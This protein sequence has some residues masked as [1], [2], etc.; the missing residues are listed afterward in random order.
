M[1]GTVYFR[2]PDEVSMWLKVLAISSITFIF[3]KLSLLCFA[4]CLKS[5]PD[6]F[7]SLT[8][9]QTWEE[10]EGICVYDSQ[11][12]QYMKIS[13]AK[14]TQNTVNL[15]S[16]KKATMSGEGISGMRRIW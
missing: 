11:K 9:F 15:N 6:A 13:K 5:L 7:I 1:V 10:R 2:E 4:L 12:K 14:K 3:Q 16:G 8:W